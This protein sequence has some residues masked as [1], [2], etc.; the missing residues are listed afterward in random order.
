MSG[1]PGHQK[2]YVC[3]S[4]RISLRFVVDGFT[5]MKCADCSLQFV[6][7]QLT[8]EELAPY[9]ERED[10][11]DDFVYTDPA[12][13]PN[14]NYYFYK[15]RDL[16]NGHV[17]P[18]RLLDVGCSSGLFLDV[19]DGWERHGIE[20][21]PGYA[22]KAIAKYG[23]NIF[24]GTLEAYPC[25]EGYFDVITL[26]D[27]FD[28]VLDPLHT[29][30]TCR[31]LLKPGGLIVIKVHNISCMYARLSG[32]KF[33]ALLPPFHMSYFSKKS[34]RVALSKTGYTMQYHRYIG[35][36]LSLKTIAYRLSHCGRP[37]IFGSLYRVLR[38]SSLGNVAVRKNLNDLITVVA[39]KNAE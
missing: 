28:H 23:S 26:Q 37:G 5:I 24:C 30:R 6:K 27:V 13:L 16:I 2:C 11:S 12:N 33:S 10:I 18:G 20:M 38:Q 21:M 39:T 4:E 29:L 31:R 15:L 32:P 19:M 1:G 7:E 9:Y 8:L 22:E 3:G 34:L 35:H 25:D 17:P 36:M 14:L